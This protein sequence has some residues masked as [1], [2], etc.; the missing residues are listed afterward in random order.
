MK[1]IKR[2]A[3]IEDSTNVILWSWPT[4]GAQQRSGT[5][6]VVE[7]TTAGNYFTV[8]YTNIA[9][10]YPDPAGI[11]DGRLRFPKLAVPSPVVGMSRHSLA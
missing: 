9:N 6:W 10:A 8:E 1:Y 5:V 11:H 3:Q 7:D 4:F 2:F